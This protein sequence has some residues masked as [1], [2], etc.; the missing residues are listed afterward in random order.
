MWKIFT[1]KINF[2]Q[3]ICLTAN[4]APDRPIQIHGPVPVYA[5]GHAKFRIYSK[6]R[7]GDGGGQNFFALFAFN[8]I[9]LHFN[10]NSI[11]LQHELR[12]MRG[13]TLTTGGI[14][15]IEKFAVEL[16][17]PGT[18]G[19]VEK[20]AYPRPNLTQMLPYK[21]KIIQTS[22]KPYCTWIGA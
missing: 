13:G 3:G 4:A 20:S 21:P 12:K 22:N 10:S 18:A 7:G 19:D 2:V 1:G 17:A 9:R 11:Q 14:S 5:T 16:T 6:S 8:S 15:A